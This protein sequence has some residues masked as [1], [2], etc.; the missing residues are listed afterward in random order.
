MEFRIAPFTSLILFFLPFLLMG[1][2]RATGMQDTI[3]IENLK[4]HVRN[5]HFDRNPRDHYFKLEQAGQYIQR[6]FLKVGLE[7]KEDP[8]QWEGR[9]YRNVVAEK[10]GKTFPDRVFILGAHYDTVPGS[11]GADDNA[12]AIAVLLEVARNIQK[13]PLDSTVKLI[14]FSIEEYDNGGSAH[15]AE[16]ARRS[17]EKILGMI[18]LEMVGFTGSK[19]DYPPYFN[20][21]HY[22][23]VG[24]FIGIIGN[25]RSRSLLERVYRS[26]K[27]HVPELPSECLLVQ[28]NGEEMEEGRLSDHS[29][30]WDQGFPA[31]MVTDTAF[32]RNPNYHLPS[33]TMETL[34]FEFMR[35]VAMGIFCSVVELAK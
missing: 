21:K 12:S 20:S 22:P 8:F 14:A 25:E 28:G 2:D 4:Q 5:I 24:D 15:Y 34:N 17:G 30:F 33:D 9:F 23:N 18:S 27:T 29:S 13:L 19:Q 6:E 3:S 26:F 16:K 7:V 1:D 32:L 31:L 10:K 35:K 11:P